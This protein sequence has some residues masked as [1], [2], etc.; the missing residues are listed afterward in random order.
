[1]GLFN[2]YDALRSCPETKYS[3]YVIQAMGLTALGEVAAR[4]FQWHGSTLRDLVEAAD[5]HLQTD[6]G[7]ITVI[8]KC[9]RPRHD[10]DWT[11]GVSP[12]GARK[13]VVQ[14]VI[15]QKAAH[16]KR[17]AIATDA[18]KQ[19]IME[20]DDGNVGTVK[21]VRW[22]KSAASEPVVAAAPYTPDQPPRY[23][24]ETRT[25][26]PRMSF[27]IAARDTEIKL[28]TLEDIERVEQTLYEGLVA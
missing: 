14:S 16:V 13:E 28:P 15:L 11:E 5:N 19:P 4:Q 3:H 2:S 25:I 18:K 23:I 7:L 6:A 22:P 9:A 10:Y 1:M 8:H 17:Y 12:A 27:W 24:Y 21:A 20:L 26:D